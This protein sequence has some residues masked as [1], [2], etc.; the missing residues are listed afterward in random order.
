MLLR[1]VVAVA[2]SALATASIAAPLPVEP[3]FSNEQSSTWDHIDEILNLLN[4]RSPPSHDNFSGNLVHQGDYQAPNPAAHNDHAAQAPQELSAFS[5]DYHR[6]GQN[7]MLHPANLGQGASP[8][9]FH[10]PMVAHRSPYGGGGTGGFQPNHATY[11][12]P[13]GQDKQEPSDFDWRQHVQNNMLHQGDF[14]QGASPT[15]FHHPMVAH[16][17]PYG[18]GGTGGFQP[19]HATYTLPAGQDK[20][21]PSDFD[22]RQHVQNNMLHQGDFGQGAS[23]TSFHHP[24][25]AHTSPYG[26]GGTGGFQPNHATYTLPAGQDKQEPSDFDWRQHV[27]NNMLHQGDFGQGASP[28]SFH[29]PMVAHRSPYGGGGTGGFQPNHAT[30]TLPAGQDKQEPS[31]FDWRQ[32]VQNNMLHQGDFGQGAS[33]T[34]FHHPMVAHTSPYGGSATGGRQATHDTSDPFVAMQ[35]AYNHGAPDD[36]SLNAMF[37]HAKTSGSKSLAVDNTASHPFS[38]QPEA[39]ASRTGWGSSANLQQVPSRHQPPA[40]AA[41]PQ[42]PAEQ[43][44]HESYPRQDEP[45]LQNSAR[46]IDSASEDLRAETLDTLKDMMVK[47]LKAYP[48]RLR[49]I[50]EVHWNEKFDPWNINVQKAVVPMSAKKAH[51]NTLQPTE[52]WNVLRHSKKHMFTVSNYHVAVQ[53]VRDIESGWRDFRL[54]AFDPA[55]NTFEY[56]GAVRVPEVIALTSDNI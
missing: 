18:G 36:W 42:E 39:G 3:P 21:E 43:A 38:Q 55:H 4:G 7:N 14:G 44:H 24:M 37:R 56:L 25:V 40:F 8:T 48:N 23:P 34:S 19:N 30:Y 53:K 20:Q 47:S 2:L 49:F 45:E 51:I 13:A 16:T 46:S 9:S 17:S 52:E 33:P 5:L 54:L 28:T 22:W 1:P 31:D 32:H 50:D 11:T 41:E 6:L 27:Q 15:S 26:G 35:R 29:Q 12:L 10:H